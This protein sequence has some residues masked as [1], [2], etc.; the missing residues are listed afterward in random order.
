MGA[1]R[2]LDGGATFQVTAQNI[3]V[4]WHSIAFS[5]SDPE[6]MAA[7][8][9]GGVYLSHDGG[10]TWRAQNRGLAISQ[11]YQGMSV[12]PSGL[13]VYAG[14]QDNSAIYYSGSTVWSNLSML[15]DGG[16]TAVNRSE[17][18]TVWVTHSFSNFVMR[19]ARGVK[20][21]SRANG[22]NFQDRAGVPRPIVM[23]PTSS[24][25]LYFGTQRL[26]RTTNEG[27][28]WS[29]ITADMSRGSGFITA[30]AIAPTDA[31]T[32]WVGTSDGVLSVTRDAGFTWQ[33]LVFGTPRNFTKILIDPLD[34]LHVIAS[35][36]TIGAPRITETRDGGATFIAALGINLPDVPVHS[37]LQVPGTNMVLAA[38]D[39][40][41]VQTN[42]GGG[43]WAQAANGLPSVIVHDLAYAPN[44]GTVFAG[45]FGRGVWAFRPG[46]TPPVLRGDVNKDGRLT[47]Q[48]A[49]LIQQA[50]VGLEL[51]PGISMWPEGD[52]NCDNQ[53]TVLDAL[54]V[55]RSAVGLP[56]GNSCVGTSAR[57]TARTG[58]IQHEDVAV[59]REVR[60]VGLALK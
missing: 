58:P 23:D 48:D 44:T 10:R 50:L 25:T 4:D 12:H 31:R 54:F 36:S 19:Q 24:A 14:L 29:A 16:Y 7:G 6:T 56:T 46:T 45:T 11:V 20:E 43:T 13:W 40:G 52:A 17:P 47:A 18:S 38:T 21:E 30:I 22:I 49:L 59:R 9:D 53:L 51:A 60:G 15:G 34:P 1:F 57:V 35:A 2:S 26:Y 55:L 41:V 28:L 8:T 3:H 42:N 32:V 37:V 39:F 33:Q 27:L 5:P